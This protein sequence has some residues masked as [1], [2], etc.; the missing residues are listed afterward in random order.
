[1][2]RAFRVSVIVVKVLLVVC[3]VATLGAG[4]C[5]IRIAAPIIYNKAIDRIAAKYDRIVSGPQ[6]IET[7]KEI[8]LP[9]RSLEVIVKEKAAQYGVF[10][11]VVWAVMEAESG[12]KFNQ[13]YRFEPGLY[14]GPKALAYRKG[15][16]DSERRMRAS[17]HGRMHCLGNTAEQFG[18]KWQE[19]YDDEIGVECGV[20]YLKL[21]LDKN[22]G[23]YDLA[24]AD[25]N[26]SSAYPPL[27][28]TALSRKI[29][30][31]N[32]ITVA[33]VKAMAKG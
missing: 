5:A 4:V 29:L 13:L 14:S 31:Q 6:T 24:L 20:R 30:A 16:S 2:K 11:P 7:T 19:L 25:Y 28:Y 17:S 1:M 18:I 32:G 22:G 27:V 10:E 9:K 21:C 33:M 12:Q 23:N 26:G 3:L 8:K 15:E